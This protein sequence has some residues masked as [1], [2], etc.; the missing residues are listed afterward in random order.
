MGIFDKNESF[1]I[2]VET[3]LLVIAEKNLDMV[4]LMILEHREK[5]PT[6]I[7]EKQLAILYQLIERII[8]RYRK[9]TEDTMEKLVRTSL[10][11]IIKIADLVPTVQ[12]PI[13]D[14]LIELSRMNS[15]V[16]LAGLMNYLVQGQP[17]H[18]MLL[19][20][21]GELSTANT[22]DIVQYLRKIF[23]ILIPTMELVRTDHLKQAYS[24]GER[25]SLSSVWLAGS[26][27]VIHFL[28]F[29]SSGQALRNHNGE[30]FRAE[31]R[32]RCR[33]HPPRVSGLCH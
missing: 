18:F 29:S 15:T 23:S 32:G 9:I 20:T 1:R 16:V 8:H 28:I 7:D 24:F 12:K 30:H 14:T 6:K 21:L 27:E 26:L 2:A 5:S 17:A 4:I 31:E 33:F 13:I 19:H 11:E 3:S 22:Q 25:F 10:E